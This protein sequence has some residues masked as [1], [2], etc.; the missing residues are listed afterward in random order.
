M[1]T[2]FLVNLY[3]ILIIYFCMCE[4]DVCICVLTSCV[5]VCDSK[6]GLPRALLELRRQAE[7]IIQLATCLFRQAL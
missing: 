2:Y 3:I 5:Y 7:V 4:R 6:H 1:I